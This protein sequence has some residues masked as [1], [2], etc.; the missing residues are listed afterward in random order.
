[1]DLGTL[2]FQKLVIYSE[3][4]Q[5]FSFS[6]ECD[7]FKN[8]KAPKKLSGSKEND[9]LKMLRKHPPS[10]KKISYYKNHFLNVMIKIY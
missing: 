10:L 3:S 6:L 2:N 8:Q 5:N 7:S 1:M 9:F 4:F